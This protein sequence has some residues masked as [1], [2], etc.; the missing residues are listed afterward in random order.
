VDSKQHDVWLDERKRRHLQPGSEQFSASGLME[1]LDEPVVHVAVL[2]GEPR[3]CPVEFMD[4]ALDTR[5]LPERFEG[6]TAH[7]VSLLDGTA[8]SSTALMRY[9]SSGDQRWRAYVALRRDGGIEAGFGATARYQYGENSRWAGVFAYRLYVIV[10]LV[11]VVID[12]QAGLIR[13]LAAD[14][15]PIE[16]A[17]YELCVALPGAGG[18]ILASF[19]DGWQEPDHSFSTQTCLERD[20][21]VRVQLDEW[22][23]TAER[24][25]AL[26]IRVADR[27]CDTFG[28][29]QRLYCPPSGSDAGE[30]SPSYA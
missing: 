13:D 14:G 9:A 24:R 10:H 7:G 15:A 28:A 16:L 26:L 21:L 30:L 6:Q 2:P 3:A 29:N 27:V 4:T 18:A 11:R 25:E 5:V 22:P 19:A 23:D 8:R 20:P 17:P 1:R 12:T